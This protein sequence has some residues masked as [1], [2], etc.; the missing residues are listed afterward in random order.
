MLRVQAE[1]FLLLREHVQHIGPQLGQL[2]SQHLDLRLWLWLCI[3]DTGFQ[4]VATQ[5]K[6]WSLSWCLQEG[7]VRPTVD[8]A[9]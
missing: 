3:T 4:V 5:A 2:S 7:D 6:L 8:A 9:G 1:P